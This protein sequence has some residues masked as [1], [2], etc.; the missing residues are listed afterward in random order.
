MTRWRAILFDLDDT[1]YPERD[2]VLSGFRAVADWA[3]G[4]GGI[5]AEQGYA[6]LTRLFERGV[7]GDTFD[8][9]FAG[10]GQTNKQLVSEAVRV[11][12]EHAPQIQPYPEVPPL[13]QRLKP[14]FKLGIVSDGYADVQKKKL[15]VL[16]LEKWFDVIVFSD[17]LGREAW[18]PSP[19]AFQKACETTAV[20]PSEAVYVGD[21]PKKDFIGARRAGVQSIWL[22]LERG[23]YGSF[24]P[25]SQEYDADLTV[26][27][28]EQLES[29]FFRE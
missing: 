5:P 2:Y 6:E 29:I 25:E 9:W 28:F 10:F 11:Y 22:R 18:K 24:A 4:R 20:L 12:R 13:L 3:Q 17:E 15:D 7:R 19:L 26:T 16:E 8:R 23:V 14:R 27:S 1:L 21:N